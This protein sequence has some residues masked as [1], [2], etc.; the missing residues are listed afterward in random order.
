MLKV[1]PN[2]SD[3]EVTIEGKSTLTDTEL[4][5]MTSEGKVLKTIQL[6][7]NKTAKVNKL[8][9]GVYMVAPSNGSAKPLPFVVR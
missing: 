6:G 2:P 7:A 5:L 1:F 8:T 4:V 3:G 9:P